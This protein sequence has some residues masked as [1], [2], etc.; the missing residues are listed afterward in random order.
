MLPKIII[1][2][3][4]LSIVGVLMWSMVFL[5]K[6]ESHK[7]CTLLLLKIRVGLSITLVLFVL[8]SYYM[9]WI[10]PHGLLQAAPK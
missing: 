9:G 5:V 8:L 7:K 6:D 3:L 1:V 4:L 10:Q 2:V